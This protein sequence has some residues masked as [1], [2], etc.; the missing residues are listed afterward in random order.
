MTG[1]SEP[2]ALAQTLLEGNRYRTL[3]TADASGR[4]WVSPVWY[5]PAGEDE[6]LWVSSPET[7]HSRNIAARPQVAIV[8]ID[9]TVPVGGAEALY[10]E[11][12]AGLVPEPEVEQ[13]IATFSERAQAGGAGVWTT[14]NVSAPVRL[15]LYRARI[16]ARFVLG[17]HDER[18]PVR[19]LS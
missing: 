13:A 10:L 11:A 7:R 8:I 1:E 3:G 15:R 19:P 14:A 2:A 16:T 4:P 9:S 12:E 5:A 18:L 17:P 6:L